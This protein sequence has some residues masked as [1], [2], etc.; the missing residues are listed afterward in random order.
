MKEVQLDPQFDNF[1]LIKPRWIKTHKATEP[2]KS[3]FTA[4]SSCLGLLGLFEDGKGTRQI[5]SFFWLILEDDS[6]GVTNSDR[7]ETVTR[8]EGFD[9]LL[10]FPVKLDGNRP[11]LDEFWTVNDVLRRESIGT[12]TTMTSGVHRLA[13][14]VRIRRNNCSSPI[15]LFFFSSC[16]LLPLSRVFSLLSHAQISLYIGFFSPFMVGLC[17]FCVNQCI[18]CI[19]WKNPMWSVRVWNF[20]RASVKKKELQ[21]WKKRKKKNCAWECPPFSCAME[22]YIVQEKKIKVVPP[23]CCD[24]SWKFPQ[25]IFPL[26]PRKRRGSRGG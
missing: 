6:T 8:K 7:L 10:K 26:W 12:T 1:I 22:R 17:V 2:N 3:T 14:P 18:L 9:I 16:I 24:P 20:C 21:K 15:F 25:C 5:F 11:N 23:S 19:L 4:N 13:M